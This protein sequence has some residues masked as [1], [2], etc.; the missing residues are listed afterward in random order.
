MSKLKI[1]VTVIIAIIVL[2]V[3]AA[4]L[5]AV[6]IAA[7]K[8]LAACLSLVCLGN[9]PLLFTDA[10]KIL[11]GTMEIAASTAVILGVLLSLQTYIDS[12]KAKKQQIQQEHY[13]SFLKILSSS[14]IKNILPDKRNHINTIYQACFDTHASP[15]T[16]SKNYKRTIVQISRLIEFSN[17]LLTQHSGQFNKEKHGTKL[18]QYFSQLGIN[19]QLRRNEDI[20]AHEEVVFQLLDRISETEPQ[21]T[22]YLL[23]IPRK[24]H[25]K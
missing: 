3:T 16:L 17:S 12:E 14:S 5:S 8:K 9:V 4:G 18:H 7:Q 23:D 1:T 22:V 6:A 20:E 21:D 2:G 15:I 19:L 11:A 25:Y 10:F 24:Y 13:N